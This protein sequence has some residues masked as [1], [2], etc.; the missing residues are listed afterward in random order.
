MPSVKPSTTVEEQI[1]LYR[2]RG[3]RV[4][5]AQAMQWLHAVGYYRLSGYAYVFREPESDS[6]VPG[7]TFDDV[8]RLYEFDRKL[9]T[10]VYDGIP[11]EEGEEE[12]SDRRMVRT[13]EHRSQLGGASRPLVESL[14]CAG[15]VGCLSPTARAGVLAQRP[16]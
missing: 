10:L 4:D 6:F 2:S 3:M 11:A 15:V 16:E 1:S 13:A 5:E 12:A 8:T 14:L 7:T 9:R